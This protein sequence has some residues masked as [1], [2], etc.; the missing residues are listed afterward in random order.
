MQRKENTNLILFQTDIKDRAYFPSIG[1]ITIKVKSSE[2]IGCRSEKKKK[3]FEGSWMKS[4]KKIEGARFFYERKRDPR[5]SRLQ[6]YGRRYFPHQSP[7]S[8]LIGRKK[9]SNPGNPVLSPKRIFFARGESHCYQSRMRPPRV[10]SFHARSSSWNARTTKRCEPLPRTC[11]N[12]FIESG[13]DR[14]L[15]RAN[16]IAPQINPFLIL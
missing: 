12:R 8:V 7:L 15:C 6:F 14:S 13:R 10:G 1:K 2:I 9:G 11:A 5:V 3:K 4:R 16:F